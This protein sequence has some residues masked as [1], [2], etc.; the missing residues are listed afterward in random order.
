MESK[1]ILSVKS[2]STYF[3][4]AEGTVKAVQDVSFDLHR[5]EVLGIV[6]ETGS[7]KSV[8]VKSIAGLIDS[9][10]RIAKGDISLL[11]EEFSKNNVEEYVNLAKLQYEKFSRIRGKHIGMI[12][13]DPM[14]SLDPMYTIGNQMIETIVHHDKVSESEAKER[15]IKLLELVGIPKPSERI[16]DYPF[17]LSGG[18]RQRVVI[19][20][21]LSCNPE[22]LISD[23]PTTA[24]DVTV[25]AQ[26]LELMKDLQEEYKSGMIFITHDLAVIA[27]IAS[28]VSIMYGSYQM[29][30]AP[31]EKVYSAARHPYTYALLSC[32]PRLDIKQ[33]ELLPIPGQPPVMMDPPKLCPYLPRCRRSIDKCKKILPDLIEIEENHFVRCNNPVAKK[34]LVKEKTE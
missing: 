5:N 33:E 23:E 4:M 11:T 10:G 22:V 26:I 2:L 29:E 24:L 9:P 17:Q 27:E 19:A 30:V 12:F 18:Q 3:D 34:Y 15:S 28:K 14:T 20:I 1:P 7:G 32:I 8:T 13:Q 6:G 16:N 25:Q 21:A 31:V